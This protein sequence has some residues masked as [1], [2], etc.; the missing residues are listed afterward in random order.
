MATGNAAYWSDAPA[1]AFS[2]G[3]PP[4]GVPTR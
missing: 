1:D 3:E 2:D 4:L